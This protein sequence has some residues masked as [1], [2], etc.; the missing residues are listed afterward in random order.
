M[1]R[2]I[3]PKVRAAGCSSA[4]ETRFA[5]ELISDRVLIRLAVRCRRS[6]AELALADLLE[7]APGGVEEVEAPNG[8]VDVIEYAIYGA[9]GELPDV[10]EL[11]AA[12]GEALVEVRSERVPDDWHERWK[13]F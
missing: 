10:G 12:A 3:R 1:A 7:L 4:F 13:R 8:D 6:E 5:V 2:T 9:A 11:R